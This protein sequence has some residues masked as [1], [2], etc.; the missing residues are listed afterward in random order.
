MVRRKLI[1]ATTATDNPMGAQRYE[2]E[3]INGVPRTRAD[4]A[5]R[6]VVSRSMRSPLA[7][8][9]RLPISWLTTANA[10][11]R[12]IA[13]AIFFPDRR[14]ILHRMD[15]VIPPGQGLNTVTIHDTVSWR[16]PDESPPVAAAAE[17]ARRAD[18]VICVS[19]F[20]ANEAQSM[21]GVSNPVVVYNGVDNKYFG[22]DPLTATQRREL[23]LDGPYVLH[24]GGAAER[25]NLAALAEAWPGIHRHRPDVTLALCGPEHPRRTDLFRGAPGVRLLGRQPEEL[26]P[27]LVR[28]SAVIV[29]PST[30][31]GF[32]LP[33]LEAM[34]AGVPVV[35]AN[36][37]ALP[38]V[39]GNA[40][41]LVEPT[42]H[43]V[44]EGVLDALALGRERAA[45][46]GLARAR[47]AEFTWERCI[48]GHLAVWESLT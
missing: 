22:A 18:A 13:G 29:V 20:S 40:G 7:G 48:A 26:M 28:S 14:A 25:K 5:V 34:A 19:A 38:E 44:R 23:R 39:V 27:S 47:A 41:I 21:L 8:D 46:V 42:A 43:G 31:E 2:S 9:R 37:S 3:L 17:E 24:A 35:A 4:W 36:R 6:H 10:A 1:L 32:G 16:F 45:L 33:A 15:L 11:S 30:Y 12:G